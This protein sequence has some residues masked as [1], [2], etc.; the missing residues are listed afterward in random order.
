[1]YG[2]CMPVLPQFKGCIVPALIALLYGSKSGWRDFSQLQSFFGF[3]AFFPNFWAPQT[4]QFLPMRAFQVPIIFHQGGG[5][6]RFIGQRTP[7]PRLHQIRQSNLVINGWDGMSDDE[8]NG[9]CGINK[10]YCGLHFVVGL[11]ERAQETLK[12]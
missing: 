1:M 4:T 6:S 12:R 8:R 3:R 5:G 11:A 10:S 2:C 9:L 7:F